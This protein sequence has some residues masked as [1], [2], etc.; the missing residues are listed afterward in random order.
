MSRTTRRFAPI[1]GKWHVMNFT[2]SYA[3]D[4]KSRHGVSYQDYY[5]RD[6]KAGWGKQKKSFKQACSRDLRLKN[7][8]LCEDVI[9][10]EDYDDMYYPD[11]CDGKRFI[12]DY[13]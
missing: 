13:F 9:R 3:A 1:A 8:R 4:F 6:G 7:R 12:W 11:T 2:P 5:S 10:G